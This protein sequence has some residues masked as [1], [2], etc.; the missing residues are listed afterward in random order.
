MTHPSPTGALRSLIEDLHQS[1][2]RV[3]RA[4]QTVKA[5][6]ALLIGDDGARENEVDY[7]FPAATASVEQVNFALSS[8]K[9]LLC[10]SLSPTR[11]DALGFTTAP[12]TSGLMA[13]TGFTISVDA[14]HNI[15]SGISARDRA[16]TI[17]LMGADG[18]KPSDFVTPG[19]VFPVRA[20]H[21]G[22]FARTGH[23][24]AVL[25][26]CRLAGIP[27]A[28]A[29]CEV[30]G[31]DGDALPVRAFEQPVTDDLS[32]FAKLPYVSTVDLM[33]YRLLQDRPHLHPLNMRAPVNPAAPLVQ[34]Q[35][36]WQTSAKERC[37]ALLQ[38]NALAPFVLPCALEVPAASHSLG[39]P[40]IHI[41]S[42]LPPRRLTWNL[43]GG[44]ASQVCGAPICD[45]GLIVHIF[46]PGQLNTPLPHRIDHFCDLSAKDGIERIVPSVRRCLTALIA[47]ETLAKEFADASATAQLEWVKQALSSY[48][49]TDD[50]A[51]LL[52]V[53]RLR[54]C[55]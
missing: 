19:H 46:A 44:T 34:M 43:V 49:H 5:G 11:A 25:E 4:I 54:T 40:A 22:L 10:V 21:A 52:E 33:W 18:A 9:G 26:L 24:E 14:R 39:S 41:P 45:S 55:L 27:E 2:Q 30:L 29:M 1:T 36:H 31:S 35:P 15:T 13:H 7:V 48:P 50:R 20:E 6:Q 8:C 37:T 23:T 47:A 32:P 53:L 3:H 38:N 42:S 16:V 51:F 28:A 12:R 17:Q